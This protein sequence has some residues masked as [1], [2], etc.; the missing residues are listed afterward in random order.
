MSLLIKDNSFVYTS[1]KWPLFAIKFKESELDDILSS[2][3]SVRITEKPLG[4]AE[5]LQNHTTL[6][7]K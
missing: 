2:W 1:S 5:W 6:L 3:I 4:F 7:T